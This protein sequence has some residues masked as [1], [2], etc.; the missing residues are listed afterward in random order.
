MKRLRHPETERNFPEPV[1]PSAPAS[2]RRPSAGAL[3]LVAD[4]YPDTRELLTLALREAGFRVA[5]ASDGR[6]ALE[7]AW[8]L[9][10]DLILMDLSMPVLD[11]RAA[12]LV[13]KSDPRSQHIPVVAITCHD[14]DELGET[15]RRIPFDAVVRKPCLPEDVAELVVRLLDDLESA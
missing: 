10:P 6:M 15:T 2:P 1:P 13:L 9:A 4:D 14:L 3:V 11:G 7:R 12:T 5:E 8:T